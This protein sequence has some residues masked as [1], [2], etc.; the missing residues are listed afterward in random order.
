[1]NTRISPAQT[2]HKEIDLWRPFLRRF[3]EGE[4][5]FVGW[6][7]WPSTVFTA[8]AA[9]DLTELFVADKMLQEI[10]DRTKIW[11]SEEIILPTLLALL[12]YEIAANPCSYD[13]V[14]Y[15]TNY[16]VQQLRAAQAR[17]DVF[18][19]HPVP[20]RYNDPLR[21]YIRTSFR[22]YEN[23]SEAGATMQTPTTQRDS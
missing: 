18:W 8:E 22:N 19:V 5:K 16:T 6:S 4:K 3:P 12:G 11:A 20:R 2:A 1:P 15:K 17:A 23:G 9:R 10:M 7:F 13:Y 14:K 21:Q